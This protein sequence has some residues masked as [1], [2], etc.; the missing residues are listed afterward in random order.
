MYWWPCKD[1]NSTV[2]VQI[3]EKISNKHIIGHLN[4]S[5]RSSVVCIVHLL[6]LHILLSIDC[7]KTVSYILYEHFKLW[8]LL[9]AVKLPYTAMKLYLGWNWEKVLL[10]TKQQRVK[11]RLVH[12]CI[13]F[14]NYTTRQQFLIILKIILK[15][16]IL[17]QKCI[18]CNAQKCNTTT[19]YDAD[20]I[21]VGVFS[22]EHQKN[23]I[24]YYSAL[25]P[26]DIIGF[27]TASTS[28]T[29]DRPPLDIWGEFPSGGLSIYG[30]LFRLQRSNVHGK[31]FLNVSIWRCVNLSCNFSPNQFSII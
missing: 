30:A 25:V 2:H 12:T 11:P 29:S 8:I 4:G 31:S 28:W 15:Y 6:F 1:L 24:V 3:Q 26:L 20:S 5:S 13:F 19:N 14:P 21:H 16:G 23:L 7:S 18:L 9:I 17:L 22:Q 10:S 27:P